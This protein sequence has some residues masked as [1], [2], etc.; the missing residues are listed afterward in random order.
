MTHG[1]TLGSIIT[2]GDGTTHGTTLTSMAIHG[3]VG[4]TGM[5]DGMQAMALITGDI[6]TTITTIIMVVDIIQVML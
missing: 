2:D 3:M 4:T 5:T 1:T 6:I